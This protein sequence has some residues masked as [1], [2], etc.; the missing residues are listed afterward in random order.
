MTYTQLELFA[1][2]TPNE[3]IAERIV[4]YGVRGLGDRE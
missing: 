4:Q 1:T 2:E 3:A